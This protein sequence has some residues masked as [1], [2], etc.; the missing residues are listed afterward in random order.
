MLE[1]DYVWLGCAAALTIAACGLERS[2]TRSDE[3]SGS[4]TGSDGGDLFTASSTSVGG[5]GSGASTG[6]GMGGE[7]GSGGGVQCNT[8]EQC[9]GDDSDCSFRTCEGNVCGIA[10]PAAGETCDDDGGSVCDGLGNCVLADGDECIEAAE[11]LSGICA[12]GVCCDDACEG[13]CESCAVG[14][15]EGVC[16]PYAAGTDPEP[17]CGAGVC[18]GVNACALGEHLWSAGY[19][20]G[21]DQVARA[22]ASDIVGNVLVAGI[23]RGALD[24]S[25]SN[26]LPTFTGDDVFLAKLSPS[27][28]YMWSKSF[29]DSQAQFGLGVASDSGNN[30]LLTG[31]Y[32]TGINFS[33]NLN[34]ALSN[35]GKFD[36]FI[37]KFD[38]NGAHLWSHGFGDDGDDFGRKVVVDGNDDVIIAG[39][40]EGELEFET[41]A[42]L[43]A[44]DKF[45]MF[46][47]KFDSAGNFVWNVSLGGTGDDFLHEL[48]V[49]SQGNVLVAGY[50]ADTIDVGAANPLDSA[51]NNDALVVQ[52]DGGGDYRWHQQFGD[53]GD[54][55]ALGIVAGAADDVFVSGRVGGTTDFGGGDRVAIGTDLFLARFDVDG[56]YQSDLFLAAAG[57]QD[58]WSLASDGSNVVVSGTN[59]ATINLGGDDL[60]SAGTVDVVL[61]KFSQEL[62]HLWSY[63]F[64]NPN[65]QASE[66]V[67][68]DPDGNVLLVGGFA[69]NSQFGGDEL[70]NGGALD[71]FVA[72]YGP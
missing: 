59:D 24:F 20:A 11:C 58:A 67:A 16:T 70:T 56:T 50:F 8:P 15:S 64:A 68:V 36:V 69:G 2:G 7:G 48:A 34:D 1:D 3:P 63:G 14:G 49:D 41:G 55:Y 54:Q 40:F 27:G 57:D 31:R 44:D 4:G 62:T 53:G 52:L 25:G 45:D 12:D 43:T 10:L 71:V 61:A 37:A 5:Q 42:P 32:E 9:E 21:M 6:V 30:V 60:V 46:V 13:V 35:A 28:G 65:T 29:G 72:K 22:V 19:G 26:P 33:D 38:T 47:A 66:K 18:D 23:F 51:G 39:R 17:E